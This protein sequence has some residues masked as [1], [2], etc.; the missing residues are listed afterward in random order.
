[1]NWSNKATLRLAIIA[2]L[3]AIGASPVSADA[4]PRGDGKTFTSLTYRAQI[5][6]SVD[7]DYTSFY[8]EYG[9]DARLTFGLD[10]GLNP[11]NGDRTALAF[12]RIPVFEA[13]ENDRF[14]VD[15]GVGVARSS[16]RSSATGRVGLSWGRGLAFGELPGWVGAD[17]SLLFGES[18]IDIAKLDLTLGAT[19]QDSSLVF[20]QLQMAQSSDG[21]FSLLIAPSVALA[22]SPVLKFEVGLGYQPYTDA[23]SVKFGLWTEF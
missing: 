16:G 3:S 14:A 5:T 18:A 2:G 22:I 11:D 12:L 7:Q 13:A 6:D 15:I 8:Y 10:V 20:L 19:L 1:M 17:G 4:W 23:K 9:I 21:D